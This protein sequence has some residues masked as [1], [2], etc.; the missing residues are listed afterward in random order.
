MNAKT[1]KMTRPPNKIKPQFAPASGHFEHRLDP[2]RRY[3]E[4]HVWHRR[5]VALNPNGTLQLDMAPI[6]YVVAFFASG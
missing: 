2:W 1:S 6:L 5:D 4:V 3:P